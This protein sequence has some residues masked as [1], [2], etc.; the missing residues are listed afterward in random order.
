MRWIASGLHFPI[1]VVD[2]DEPRLAEDDFCND[3]DRRDSS[4]RISWG[5]AT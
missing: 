4:A 2:V 1:P 5:D 3:E